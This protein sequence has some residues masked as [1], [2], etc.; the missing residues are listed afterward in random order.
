MSFVCASVS[1]Y[2]CG[3]VCVCRKKKFCRVDCLKTLYKIKDREVAGC[4]SCD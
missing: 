1:V 4:R 2:G 3:R